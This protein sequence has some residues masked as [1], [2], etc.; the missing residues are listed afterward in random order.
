[1]TTLSQSVYVTETEAELR[2]DKFLAA[3]FPDFSRTYFQY[4]IDKSCVLVNGQVVKKRE[5]LQPLDEIEVCFELTPELSVVPEAIALDILFEDE[6]LLI[7]N[8][9]AGMVVHPAPGHPT[10]TFVNA[11]LHHCNTLEVDSLRPGIVHRLDKD[12]SGVLV[13]AKTSQVHAQLVSLFASRQIEKHYIAV[14]LGNPGNVVINAPLKRHPVRRQEMAVREGGKEAISECHIIGF[15]GK[16]SCVG[17]KLITGRTH[18]IRVH[19]KS[20]GTPVLGDQ[21]YGSH[22]ANALFGASRQLL[23]AHR[24]SFVHPVTGTLL[25]IE[26]PIPN[27][28]KTFIKNFID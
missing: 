10:G 13:A 16:L 6:H 2:L 5:K 20:R 28:I 24:L 17:V 18:Q 21:V 15:D 4:L 7:V 1:M 26:A 14:C 12:T 19:L 11:L 3:K 23:H 9:P 22:T 8:K 25:Q 27:D